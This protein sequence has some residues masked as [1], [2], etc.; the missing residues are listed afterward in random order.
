MRR[1]VLGFCFRLL[2]LLLS[3]LTF[4]KGGGQLLM[5]WLRRRFPI[6]SGL[7]AVLS[8][9]IG[10]QRAVA[11]WLATGCCWP[12]FPS[13]LTTNQYPNLFF[14][15]L[16]GFFLPSFIRYKI[17]S[18]FLRF[19]F[20]ELPSVALSDGERYRV[21]FFFLPSFFL[22]QGFDEGLPRNGNGFGRFLAGFI[23]VFPR[24]P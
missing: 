8:S 5:D 24:F 16:P 15:M 23:R 2:H 19:S 9:L 22:L 4:A 17:V 12:S 10:R 7:R 18:L 14:M 1:T 3:S 13:N 6:G 20:T 21:F 11:C